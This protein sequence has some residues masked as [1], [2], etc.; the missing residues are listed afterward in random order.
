MDIDPL[1]CFVLATEASTLISDIS[2]WKLLLTVALVLLN[3]FFVASEF[4]IVKIRMSQIE[5]RTDLN[6]N[7]TKT[8]KTIVSNLD[9]YLA[10]TQLGITLASLGLGWVGEGAISPI[11][12]KILAVFN[13]TGPGWEATAGS[14]AL[15]GA[16][17][18]ITILHIVFGELAPKSLAI[19][20]PSNATFAVAWPL[21]VFYMI[22]KPVIWLMNGFA[23]F[24]LKLIGIKPVHGS[25]IHSEEE[26][27]MLITESQEGGA[28]EETERD[29]IQNVFEFDDRRVSNIQTLRKNV[30]AVEVGTTVKEAI[31]YAIN[32]GYSRYPVYEENLDNI[33]GILYTK[34]LVKLTL[35]K[36][37]ETN[38]IS[39]LRKP[40]FIS[41]NYKIK[42]LLKQFQK[43]RIQMAVVTNEIGE[44]T[45]IVSMEDIL[46]ELVGEIQDEYDNEDPIVISFGEGI[47]SVNAHSSLSDINRLLPYRFEESDH[48]D[49]LSGMLAETFS[50]QDLKAGD[51]LDLKDYQVKI[52][53]MYRNSVER[54]ELT[55][56]H[57]LP[58]EETE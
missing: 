45:G 21:R 9:A 26:L 48:Y 12:V 44:L 2:V 50:D 20:Y 38:F 33:K 49:T 39:I 57:V 27:K 43:K 58:E 11:I 41:E 34:D 22:F 10:A 29:L 51:I 54:V 47:Y 35:E 46:E 8:A 15:W 16:F 4:A 1:L 14:I 5:I 36:P 13:L 7:L 52:I 55:L 6:P 32:E 17:G 53:K 30:S 40:L 19:R 3:A 42:N 56:T 23:N 37:D 28:I 25:E 31:D 24:F 18:V